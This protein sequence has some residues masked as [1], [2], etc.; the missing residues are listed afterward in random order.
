M[1]DV[2]GWLHVMMIGAVAWGLWSMA[3]FALEGR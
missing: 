3:V 1:R 2:L